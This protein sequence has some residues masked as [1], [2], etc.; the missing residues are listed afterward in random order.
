MK[1]AAYIRVSTE[2]Q[3]ENY[4]IPLQVERI[5]G[6]CLSRGWDN[7]TEFIDGGFSGSNIKRPELQKLIDSIQNF[8]VVVVYRLD[9][10]SRSQKDTL[11]L[12]EEVFLP[13]NVEFI[14]ISET[15]D[16]SS[17][18]GRA[19]I[20]ILSVFA[21]LERET[22]TERL[23][24]GRYRMVKEEGLWGGGADASPTGYIRKERGRLEINEEEAELV[25]RIFK[26][27]LLTQSISKI[28]AKF[29]KENLPIW[30]FN[31]YV[32]ILK[33]RLYIGEVTFSGKRFKGSH[34]P[35]IS[36]EDFDKV[37]VYLER[38]K[39]KNFG[40]IK[41]MIFSSRIKCAH[42]GEN[43]LTYTKSEKLS[44][45]TKAT[46][47]YYICRRRR[48]PREFDSKCYNKTLK[49][50]VIE[51][52]IFAAIDNMTYEDLI[53][54][55]NVKTVDY[56]TLIAKVDNKIKKTLD[57]YLDD[58]FS[59]GVLDEKLE[60]LQEEKIKLYEQKDKQERSG[61]NQEILELLK[62]KTFKMN[63][64]D[65]DERLSIVQLLIDHITVDNGKI[66]IYWN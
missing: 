27:Y 22:I 39:G 5:K 1:V 45:G 8:D 15:I 11:Y 7:V 50:E 6:Y 62:D 3:L 13:N 37:Q 21:Q 65:A 44:N 35:L 42:C 66:N 9:R 23:R 53:K 31:R 36:V 48:F 60:E 16:T 25:R 19:M 57:L 32:R 38:H 12:I 10:L 28:Q 54:M 58:R 47:R 55:K 56:S 40:K 18:F 46:Y 34:E 29:E 41:H 24:S 26:E 61:V 63:E 20:G 2:Q 52:T 33:N 17:A 14:S 64:I 59:E 30:R 51:D 43:Y 49:K 4:S